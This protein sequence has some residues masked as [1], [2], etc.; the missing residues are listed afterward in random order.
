[1]AMYVLS[2]FSCVLLFATPWTAAHQ[3]PLSMRFPRQE[4][5][6]GL[7]CPPPGDLPNPGIQPTSLRSPALAGRFFTTYTTWE[8][9]TWLYTYIYTYIYIYI[10]SAVLKKL[11]QI[12][13]IIS[14][15]S[16]ILKVPPMGSHYLLKIA[17]SLGNIKTPHHR[18][19]TQDLHNK[20]YPLFL[21][22]DSN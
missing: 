18:T 21:D 17:K 6:S 8:S 5:W 2:H 11:V 14:G 16:T 20:S 12:S 22:R 10:T 1:M 13:L 7:P 4:Y 9:H 15:Q 3:G 19:N